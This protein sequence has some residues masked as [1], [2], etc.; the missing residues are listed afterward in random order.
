L[1][2]RFNVVAPLDHKYVK[3]ERPLTPLALIHP[4]DTPHEAGFAYK[5]TT[6]DNAVFDTVYDL[7]VEQPPFPKTVTE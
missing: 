4:S 6:D 3:G 5:L 2:E 1:L 7:V